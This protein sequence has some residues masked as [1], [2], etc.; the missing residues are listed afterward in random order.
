MF[1]QLYHFQLLATGSFQTVIAISKIIS[2]SSVSRYIAAALD[3][4]CMHAKGFITFPK[5]G[6][7]LEI[8]QL[9]QAKNGF[10]LVLGCIDCS[11]V[12][13]IQNIK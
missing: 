6:V 13:I 2:Q 12:P 5:Q 11:H 7:Q 3:S 4:L 10:L 8:E 9:F 1:T